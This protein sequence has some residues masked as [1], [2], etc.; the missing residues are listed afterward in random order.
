MSYQD[1]HN[2]G[3]VLGSRAR[4]RQDSGDAGLLATVAAC[5]EI[6]PEEAGDLLQPQ[7]KEEG[8]L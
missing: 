7:G 3:I 8:A 1:S 2:R 6:S 5:L 4:L